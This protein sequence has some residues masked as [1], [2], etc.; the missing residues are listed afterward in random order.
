VPTSGEF[1]FASRLVVALTLLVIGATRAPPFVDGILAVTK[2]GKMAG[3][4][5]GSLT[6]QSGS[7]LRRGVSARAPGDVGSRRWVAHGPGWPGCSALP[8][9]AECFVSG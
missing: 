2:R 5:A 7:R 1:S 4:R 6:R 9:K 8:V 3:R